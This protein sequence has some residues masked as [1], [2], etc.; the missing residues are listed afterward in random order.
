MT[1]YP[2][3]NAQNYVI[4]N[5]ETDEHILTLD[6]TDTEIAFEEITDDPSLNLGVAATAEGY[7][8]SSPEPT[9]YSDIL[10]EYLPAPRIS[11]DENNILTITK[12]DGAQ[13]YHIFSDEAEN[14]IIV[15]DG[16][17]A[18]TS[19]DSKYILDLNGYELEAGVKYFV[20]PCIFPNSSTLIWSRFVTAFVYNP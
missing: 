11:I 1:I 5:L 4:T 2:V 10:T 8:D 7:L 19:T 16:V 14:G 13:G 20:Q 6:S 18:I 17:T 3:E 12:V 9:Y 15:E